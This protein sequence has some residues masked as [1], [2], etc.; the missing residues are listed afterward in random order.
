MHLAAAITEERSM[1][2]DRE[3]QEDVLNALDWEP[4]VD[5]AKIGVTVRNGV[6]TLQGTVR[7]HYEKTTADHAA[8]H[9]FG[10]RA[11]ANELKV[12]LDGLPPRS[13]ASIAEAVA[14]ALAWDSAV[15]F[16]TIKALAADGWVTLTGTVDWQFQKSAAQIDVERLDGV[17]GVVNSITI[18]PRVI[19]G[20]VKT[21]IERA[22]K[23]SAEI[24]ASRVKVEAQDG[25]IVLTGTVK[26]LSE[27]AEAERAAWS[28]PGVTKV[29]DH[30]TVSPF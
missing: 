19:P 14:N 25:K 18:K 12:T 9:V 24:D 4:G 23:R 7:T 1:R 28:A 8:A 30:L 29:E 2:T 10:I 5:A 15:P 16:K 13:D 20:D 11:V 3:L 17:K 21:K 27:R 22:F 6:A 26:S